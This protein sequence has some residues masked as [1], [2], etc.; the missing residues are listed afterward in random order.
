MHSHDTAWYFKRLAVVIAIIIVICSSGKSWCRSSTLTKTNME[1][2]NEDFQKSTLL[3][4]EGPQFQ[5]L[6]LLVFECITLLLDSPIDKQFLVTGGREVSWGFFYLL[7]SLKWFTLYTW[8]LQIGEFSSFEKNWY[9]DLFLAT[10][11]VFC[12]EVRCKFERKGSER[13]HTLSGHK[14]IFHQPRFPQNKVV[15]L[16]KPPFG[17]KS[18]V[19]GRYTL[20]RYIKHAG[21]STYLL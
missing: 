12:L 15:S 21:C 16:T 17:G 11:L 14:Q 8:R 19:R 4:Q 7:F 3:F 20:P 10:L 2:E 1:L 6:W 9:V 13:V 18:V 5:V